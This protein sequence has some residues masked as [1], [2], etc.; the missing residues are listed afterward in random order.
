MEKNGERSY[1]EETHVYGRLWNL[2]ACIIF[3]MFPA[4][5]CII[6]GVSPDW[7]AVAHGL[8]ATMAVFTPMSIIESLTYIPLLGA[9]G[10]YLA[11]TTGNLLNLKIPCAVNSMEIVGVT[12]DTEEGEII[13]T[14]AMAASSLVTVLVILTGVVLIS[15]SGFGQLLTHP[16]L[17]PAFD[18]IQAALFGALGV[19]FI[20]K[21][22]R[23][24]VVPV[25]ISVLW[26]IFGG[27]MVSKLG[28]LIVTIVVIISVIAARIMY[29]NGF[30]GNKPAGSN[31]YK[32]TSK[33][34]I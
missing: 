18:C 19:E 21:D 31:T 33:E 20:S 29:K 23:S 22:W 2:G 34:I 24:A 13:S 4:S 16:T 6:W 7:R 10:A 5:I 28:N 11:W 27:P 1:I 14:I 25:A 15:V 32:E 3:L 30:Y 12:S 26:Y 8:L 9:G 17:K